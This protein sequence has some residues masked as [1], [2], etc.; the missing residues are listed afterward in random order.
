[1]SAISQERE[2][3]LRD[4]PVALYKVLKFEGLVSSGAVAKQCIADGEVSVNAV[5]ETRKRRQIR[6]GDRISFADVTLIA[7]SSGGISGK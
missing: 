4:E 6:V 1:M 2:V 7:V 3:E 5:V